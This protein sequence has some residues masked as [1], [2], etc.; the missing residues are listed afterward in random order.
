MSRKLF[1]FIENKLKVVK[2]IFINYINSHN[3]RLIATKS[4]REVKQVETTKNFSNDF[5]KWNK[6]SSFLIIICKTKK[7]N[8]I[9]FSLWV[10]QR[11]WVLGNKHTLT[12]KTKRQGQTHVPF[13]HYCR[14]FVVAVIV[15]VVNGNKT[16]FAQNHFP[17]IIL[18]CVFFFIFKLTNNLSF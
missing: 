14:A 12:S 3:F 11:L 17:T 6:R 8:K 10:G 2:L 9:H 1:K 18:F 7:G 5:S 13:F 16:N 4:H 15:A